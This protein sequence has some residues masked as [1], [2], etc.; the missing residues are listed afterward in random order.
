MP[1]FSSQT[2]CLGWL[3]NV[4][5]GMLTTCEFWFISF[6]FGRRRR[7]QLLQ[8]I[9]TKQPTKQPTTTN[10]PWGSGEDRTSR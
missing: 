4:V 1:G 3:P 8:P 7:C 5:L 6:L 2:T 10:P 9:S